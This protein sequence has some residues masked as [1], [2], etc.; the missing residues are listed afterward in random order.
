MECLSAI[1]GI[2]MQLEGDPLMSRSEHESW[3]YDLTD[4]A[5]KT[6]NGKPLLRAPFEFWV[7][8]NVLAA[9]QSIAV[10]S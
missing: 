6:A 8:R 3:P 10:Q 1:T 5:A 7:L 4:D 2:P 9:L